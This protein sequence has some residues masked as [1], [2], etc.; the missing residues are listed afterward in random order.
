MRVFVAGSTG[1]GRPV[2]YAA[3]D[4]EWTRAGGMVSSK[5]LVNVLQSN[6]TGSYY[7]RG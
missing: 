6:N 4:R 1:A 7:A 3:S 2:S 5:G